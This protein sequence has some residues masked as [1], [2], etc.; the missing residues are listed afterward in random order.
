MK[1]SFAL[2]DLDGTLTDPAEGIT[3]AVM[4]ALGKFGIYISDRRDL[5]KFIGPPLKASFSEYYGFSEENADLALKYY[6][7]Y[8][9]EKGIFENVKYPGI[10]GVLDA[11]SRAGTTISLA[12]S[13]PDLFSERILEKFGLR[14]Y[15]SFIAANTMDELRP[16][17][18]DVI[19]YAVEKLHITDPSSAIMIG[20][21]KY[22][23][24][25]GKTFGMKTLGVAYGYGGRKELE[26]AGADLIAD[27]V[28]ELYGMLI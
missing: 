15:F 18:E 27:S 2:F 1:Y 11:L 5:Y 21:R 3:N 9:S 7:E 17:K 16:T 6:R 10:D 25:G 23:I 19:A 13:K 20:D 28:G 26:D 24:V 14:K 12:T 22:D 4:Y 8:F